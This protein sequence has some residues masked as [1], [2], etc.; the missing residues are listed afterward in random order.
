M[1]KR[2]EQRPRAT[3]SHDSVPRVAKL[4]VHNYMQWSTE[5]EH[6]M[7]FKGCWTAVDP[8][9]TVAGTAPPP[10]QTGGTGLA[11]A[12]AGVPAA[13][14]GTG[15]DAT[16]GVSATTELLTAKKDRA[17]QQALSLIILNVKPQH[18]VMV[19][20]AETARAAWAALKDEFRS[21]DRARVMNLRTEVNTTKMGSSES[22][23]EYFNSGRAVV[24]ELNMLGVII[25]D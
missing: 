16:T 25:V 21:T 6:I 17:E 13:G 4:V 12:P 2:W 8:V 19:R 22:A 10:P 1:A 9:V 20:V 5:L 15:T 24:W 18:F 3:M 23:V 7:R 14:T 11:G